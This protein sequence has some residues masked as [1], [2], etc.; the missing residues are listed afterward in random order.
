MAKATQKA[1]TLDLPAV[2]NHLV[3]KYKGL[4]T[5]RELLIDRTVPFKAIINTKSART[6]MWLSEAI[7]DDEENTRVNLVGR[8]IDR[9]VGTGPDIGF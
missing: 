8:V 2:E 3:A 6:G 1:P 7:P 9:L 4:F 5:P